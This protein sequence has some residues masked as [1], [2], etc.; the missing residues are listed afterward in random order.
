MRRGCGSMEQEWGTLR[1]GRWVRGAG[2]L[3]DE[4]AATGSPICRTSKVME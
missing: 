1:D 3:D 2:S 4:V